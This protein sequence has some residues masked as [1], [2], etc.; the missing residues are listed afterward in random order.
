M[1]FQ[2]LEDDKKEQVLAQYKVGSGNTSL[3]IKFELKIPASVA[4]N[5]IPMLSTAEVMDKWLS[6]L[7][8]VSSP[9]PDI[10]WTNIKAE[11]IDEKGFLYF[12]TNFLVDGNLPTND[13]LEKY[14]NKCKTIYSVKNGEDG[15][16][17]FNM[18]DTILISANKKEVFLTKYI[19][20][21]Q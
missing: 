20:L 6:V 11:G 14:F 16:K 15:L 10:N 17:V 9:K 13:E 5:L 7:D 18:F 19:V 12:Q 8:R 2:L 4:I 1:I 3:K 21:N